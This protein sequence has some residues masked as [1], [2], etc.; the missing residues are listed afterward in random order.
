MTH[1]TRQRSRLQVVMRVE[2]IKFINTIRIITEKKAD[3]P[4]TKEKDPD[5]NILNTL[6]TE[7][8][9]RMK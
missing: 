2:Q 3:Q 8:R 4:E 5:I 1:W 6:P 7:P 9:S